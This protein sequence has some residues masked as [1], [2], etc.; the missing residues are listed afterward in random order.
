M[1]R[2]EAKKEVEKVFEP[3][4]A[5]YIIKALTDGATE[6]DVE[7]QG[8]LISR[9][10]V[11]ELTKYIS[12]DYSRER[13]SMQFHIKQLPS[14]KAEPQTAEWEVYEVL[15]GEWEG[16]KKYKC[17]C[18]GHKVGVFNTNFCPECGVKMNKG[19]RE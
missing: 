19:S 4:F 7:P 11:L 13:D 8:D 16:T 5:N 1:T 14:V 6:S 3:A 17:P 10:A 2:E 12:E 9:E 18:C 15:H